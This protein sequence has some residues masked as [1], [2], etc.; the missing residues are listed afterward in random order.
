[1]KKISWLLGSLGFVILSLGLF[2][3][4]ARWEGP[5]LVSIGSGHALSVLDT[6]AIVPLLTGVH[7]LYLGLWQR[8]QQPHEFL[9]HS[10]DIA[11]L[12]IF[13]AG[14]GLGLL[15]ASAFS[16]FFWWW[17]IGALLFGAMLI[18]ALKVAVQAEH[19][20]TLHSRF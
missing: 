9:E 13:I 11:C 17:A 18:I 5:L 12:G 2:A 19:D 16:S 8:R 3:A 20:S 7:W 10:P 1:M 4:P 14:L 15:V 6:I